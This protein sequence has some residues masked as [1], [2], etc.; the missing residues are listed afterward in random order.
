MEYCGGYKTLHIK[1]TTYFDEYSFCRWRQIN[2]ICK[3]NWY[4]LSYLNKK[5]VFDNDVR[6]APINII[7]TFWILENIW[8]YMQYIRYYI[9]DAEGNEYYWGL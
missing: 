4:I 5:E 6:R 3:R 7:T 9:Y 1:Q 8:I 2:G